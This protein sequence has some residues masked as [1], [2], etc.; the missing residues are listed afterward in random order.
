MVRSAIAAPGRVLL[1]N[2]KLTR[3]ETGILRMEL[4]KEIYE[5]T[6]LTGKPFRSGGKKHAK[7]RF[8]EYKQSKLGWMNIY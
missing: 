5:R 6:G 7:E 4:G 2:R 3:M 1:R 8:C